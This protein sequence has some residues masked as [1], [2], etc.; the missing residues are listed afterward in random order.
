MAD[1]R[2][3][4]NL[5][6]SYS[7]HTATVQG[8]PTI[9]EKAQGLGARSANPTDSHRDIPSAHRTETI[10]PELRLGNDKS[11]RLYLAPSKRG[12]AHSPRALAFCPQFAA[13]QTVL[14]SRV[15]E[16]KAA[17][18]EGCEVGTSGHC[19]MGGVR[20]ISMMLSTPRTAEE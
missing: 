16:L 17:H 4:H 8:A 5:R 19:S 3:S 10:H 20:P 6:H 7:R 12:A 9:G 14:I 1:L 11:R 18:R 2:P 13:R 15:P